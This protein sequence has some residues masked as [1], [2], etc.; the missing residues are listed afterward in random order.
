MNKTPN[1]VSTKDLSYLSDMFN[2]NLIIINKLK[3]YIN[4]VTDEDM[5]TIFSSLIDMHTNHAN[6][7]IA[8]LKEESK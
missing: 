1:M 8:I 2:W 6:T 3:L 4:E 7:I 5:K